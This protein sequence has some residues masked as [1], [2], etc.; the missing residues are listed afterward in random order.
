MTAIEEIIKKRE[1]DYLV[2]KPD[3]SF[4]QKVR[5]NQKRW[6]QIYRGEA[7]PI[8]S[9]LKAIAAFFNVEVTEIME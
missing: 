9:E 3:K 2:F 7:E 4:Y 5:V 8:A 1:V 6:G